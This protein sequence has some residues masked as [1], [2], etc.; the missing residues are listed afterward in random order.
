MRS[1]ISILLSGSIAMTGISLIFLILSPFLEKRYCA[2]TRYYMW[3]I[4]MA[5]FLLFFLPG[6]QPIFQGISL[7]AETK[8]DV[9]LLGQ[10]EGK[11]IENMQRKGKTGK[12]IRENKGREK[13]GV[14]P[15]L[16]ALWLGGFF[17]VLCYETGKHL[18]FLKL[19]KHWGQP[20]DGM[21]IEKGKIPVKL[22]GFL[23]EP[24][25]TGLFHP[26]ILLPKREY[27]KRELLFILKHEMVHYRR[28]DL[29]YKLVLLM[30]RAVHWFNP[31]LALIVR[32]IDQECEISCDEEVLKGAGE[33][34][35]LCYAEM[36]IKMAAGKKGVKS[37]FPAFFYGKGKYKI[38]KRIYA[39]METEKRR[40]G[41]IILILALAG[42]M[43]AGAFRV[44]SAEEETDSLR[45]EEKQDSES[46]LLPVSYHFEK[47]LKE[48][49]E[50]K[51][52]FGS[53]VNSHTVAYTKKDKHGVEHNIGIT[54]KMEEVIPPDYGILDDTGS[55]TVPIGSSRSYNIADFQEELKRILDE[56]IKKLMQ[57]DITD[58]KELLNQWKELEFKAAQEIEEWY[59]VN[60]S[61]ASYSSRIVDITF[62]NLYFD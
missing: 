61:V 56:K 2:K 58:R 20:F 23:T 48:L 17:W 46:E 52:R 34:E 30:V 9:S 28:K 26:M 15:L 16:S 44:I 12:D 11:K 24:M 10:Q 55:Q 57:E 27:E 3:L 1:F 45:M 39:V 59:Y 14:Y 13:R 21:E 8:I 43:T 41:T 40:A 31:F 35:R 51:G 53:G 54:I 22:C 38:K 7:P 33:T 50:E 32:R 25:L 49:K 36:L 37:A 42:T 60:E 4:I 19:L 62:D 5:G 18:H 47:V 29:W 6:K